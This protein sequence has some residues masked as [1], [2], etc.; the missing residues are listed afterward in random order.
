MVYRKPR[1]F[2]GISVKFSLAN[3]EKVTGIFFKS[4]KIVLV[5]IKKSVMSN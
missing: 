2:S 4:G 3:K 1:L 5:G